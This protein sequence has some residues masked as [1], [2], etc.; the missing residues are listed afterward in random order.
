[1]N[2]FLLD[3]FAALR[4]ARV[5]R[6]TD[7][8]EQGRA[9]GLTAGKAREFRNLRNLQCGAMAVAKPKAPVSRSATRLASSRSG[10]GPT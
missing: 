7:Y 2:T 4:P 8:N 10:Y 3:P 9:N 1:M 5:G 6:V